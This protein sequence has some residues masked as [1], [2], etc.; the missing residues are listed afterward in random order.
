MLRGNEP[1]TNIARVWDNSHLEL[2]PS[3]VTEK[4][5]E[6]PSETFS[7]VEVLGEGGEP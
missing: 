1:L 2:L 6:K 4:P 7:M 5:S 3:F